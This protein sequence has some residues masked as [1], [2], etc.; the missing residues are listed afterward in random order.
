MFKFVFF[1]SVRYIA[2]LEKN[3]KYYYSVYPF[4]SIKESVKEFNFTQTIASYKDENKLLSHIKCE[5]FVANLSRIMDIRTKNKQHSISV[6]TIKTI[7]E[8]LIKTM[9]RDSVNLQ[10]NNQ[11]LS[12]LFTLHLA[13]GINFNEVRKIY[14][15]LM[16]QNKKKAISLEKKLKQKSRLWEKN[17]KNIIQYVEIFLIN[18][19]RYNESNNVLSILKMYGD[20]NDKEI[21]SKIDCLLYDI[22][23]KLIMEARNNGEGMAKSWQRYINL[24]PYSP[25]KKVKSKK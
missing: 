14:N 16:L 2:I 25:V 1:D 5:F 3:K 7:K 19:C 6:P 22:K 17:I 12:D 18:T 23:G 15:V 11:D 20:I 9:E 8:N 24:K 21:V 10:I 13:F 4:N